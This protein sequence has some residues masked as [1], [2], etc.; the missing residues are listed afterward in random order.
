MERGQEPVENPVS[1]ISIVSD[2]DLVSLNLDT[3]VN[4]DPT[5]ARAELEENRDVAFPQNHPPRR[6]TSD[7]LAHTKTHRCRSPNRHLARLRREIQRTKLRQAQT[8]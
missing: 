4:E 7:I 2:A 8:S 5:S 6:D 3:P 1:P